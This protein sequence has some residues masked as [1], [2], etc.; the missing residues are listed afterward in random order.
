MAR[1][2]PVMT[3]LW[4]CDDKFQD[5]S[6]EGKLLF[7]YLI[8]TEHQEESGIYKTTYKTIANETDVPRDKVKELIR[9]ELS[10]NVSFDEKNNVIFVHKFLKYNGLGNP[11]LIRASVEKAKGMI[12]TSLWDEFDKHYSKDLKP[13][14]N[15]CKTHASNSIPISNS[16]S[17]KKEEA[18]LTPL[19][20]QIFTELGKFGKIPGDLIETTKYISEL[21]KEFPT[22]DP[23]DEVKAKIAHWR[24]KPLR[25]KSNVHLQLRN[26]F[27][28]AVEF[29]AEDRKDKQVGW[30]KVNPEDRLDP[31][32]MKMLTCKRCS[33]PT[34]FDSQ[35]MGTCCPMCGEEV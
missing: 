15:P 16:I 11:K 26:W 18:P 22:V 29:Q 25:K 5:Y 8:T 31:K 30:A 3:S 34:I 20:K 9:G 1:Y 13:I 6:A 10:N 24:D 17:K 21:S 28:K 35:K 23:L 27:R 32:K 12:K 33:P 14:N 2:R 7:L 19:E 4:A